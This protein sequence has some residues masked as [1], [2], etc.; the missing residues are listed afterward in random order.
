MEEGALRVDANISVNRPGE[1]LGVRT[2]VKNLN[3]IRSV[4][5]AIEFEV[6][7]QIAVLESGGIV[8]NETRSFSFPAKRTVPM[9]DKEAKQ[10]YR[11]L[12][13]PNLPPLRLCDKPSSSNEEK[14]SAHIVNIS[15]FRDTLPELP[16][17]QRQRLV[18]ETGISIESASQLVNE[19]SHLSFFEK[20]MVKKPQ[21]PQI[22]VNLLQ[23]S[24]VEMLN[25]LETTLEQLHLTPE[26]LVELADIKHKDDLPH[27]IIVKA[28]KILVEKPY[29][30]AESLIQEMNWR[31]TV[32]N[33]DLIQELV[34][35]ALK[36][37]KKLVKRYLKGKDER[38]IV[39]RLAQI[40]DENYLGDLD[41]KLVTQVI[42]NMLKDME[43]TGTQ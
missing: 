29:P 11:F 24:V 13:E 37:E 26:Q 17:A 38:K 14:A 23:S 36:N 30:S 5:N 4:S 40:V 31:E 22:L 39:V 43:K 7:R 2:E 8:E 27:N 12:P 34:T 1:P 32:R 42:R 18:S 41:M 15:D 10:D 6:D 28:V 19:P 35:K 3:S 20:A 25:N 16:N 9:R 21:S 33:M